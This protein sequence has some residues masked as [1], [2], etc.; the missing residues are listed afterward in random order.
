MHLA[1]DLT[2]PNGKFACLNIVRPYGLTYNS[3]FVQVGVKSVV[4]AQWLGNLRPHFRA[5]QFRLEVSQLRGL[6]VLKKGVKLVLVKLTC[7]E[8]L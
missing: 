5:A 4:H 1:I 8:V 2:R 6:I 3:A 7:I